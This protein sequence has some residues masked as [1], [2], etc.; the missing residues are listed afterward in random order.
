MRAAQGPGAPRWRPRLP[1]AAPQ[2]LPTTLATKAPRDLRAAA[3]D[4]RETPTRSVDSRVPKR[5]PKGALEREPLCVAEAEAGGEADEEE[6]DQDE[7]E[8]EGE[9]TDEVPPEAALSAEQ[10]RRHMVAPRASA[11]CPFPAS[12]R[13]CMSQCTFLPV[14]GLLMMRA[15]MWLKDDAPA[16]LKLA[17]E[18]LEVAKHIFLR[19]PEKY[20][21]ELAG[22]LPCPRSPA[23]APLPAL[24]C[25]EPAISMFYFRFFEQL[26]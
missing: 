1:R 19:A 12:R 15:H 13:C 7:D 23:C 20:P 21:V 17:W 25:H 9:A 3:R 10:V 14:H 18:N 22:V 4:A 11:S 8:E 16:D 6:G 26:P 5:V 2:V 24:P